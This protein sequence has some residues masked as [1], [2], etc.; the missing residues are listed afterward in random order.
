MAL[1]P[2]HPRR[3]GTR[4]VLWIILGLGAIL[5]VA[6]FYWTFITSFKSPAEVMVFPPT[7]WPA[8]PTL[9]HWIGLTQLRFGSFAAFFRNSVFVSTTITALILL[10]SSLCGYVFAK[11]RFRGRDALFVGILSMMMIPFNISII[12]LYAM[13]VDFTWTNDYR[14]LII[15]SL[16]S[17]FG[18]FLMRQFIQSIPDEL[19]DAARIDGAS[20]FGIFGRVIL[21]M[22]TAALAALAI[23]TFIAQWDDFLWP[24]V[25]IDDSKL[26]TLP[27]ALARFRGRV[28][29]DVGGLAAASL[30]AVIPVLIVYLLA[31]RRFIEGIAMTGLKG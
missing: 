3:N 31:Q 30:V 29:M 24:L 27:L 14:A 21:P 1:R 17:P 26:Y 19:L 18:I 28:T 11:H 5:M 7:W 13:M 23:F 16:Y 22:S 25:I 15:P 2:A 9:Q 20:E 12:P 10:T 4:I 6:P 8:E